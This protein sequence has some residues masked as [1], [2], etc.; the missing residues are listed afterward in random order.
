MRVLDGLSLKESAEMRRIDAGLVFFM[1]E[2][3]DF[4]VAAG[5]ILPLKIVNGRSVP[6]SDVN[7]ISVPSGAGVPVAPTVT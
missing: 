5:K 1:V 7:V 6:S 3:D 4:P 2:M